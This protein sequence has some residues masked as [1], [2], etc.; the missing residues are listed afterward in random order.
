MK[1]AVLRYRLY[2]YRSEKQCVGYA[3][4]CSLVSRHYSCAQLPPQ[5]KVTCIVHHVLVVCL[6]VLSARA[7]YF[8]P[9]MVGKMELCVSRLC[10]IVRTVSPTREFLGISSMG[11]LC[12]LHILAWGTIAHPF[13]IL[14]FRA[15]FTE[16]VCMY[17][18]VSTILIAWVSYA[19][20]IFDT[21]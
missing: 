2:I 3:S 4:R 21:H 10:I 17:K 20:Y 13:C 1:C 11:C 9:V 16:R 18:L 15:L 14:V 12:F 8:L 6:L 5:Y 19:P 7:S